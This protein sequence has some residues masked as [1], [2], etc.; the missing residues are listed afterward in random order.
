MKRQGAED[1]GF[2]GCRGEAVPRPRIT[3]RAAFG[4]MNPGTLESSNPTY[5]VSNWRGN[6]TDVA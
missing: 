3:A 4:L 2:K 1:L 5:I 6:K